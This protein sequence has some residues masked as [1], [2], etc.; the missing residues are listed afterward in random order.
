MAKYKIIKLNKADNDFVDKFL[1]DIREDDRRELFAM[2]ED[3]R[4]EIMESITFSA[5]C[6]AAVTEETAEPIVVFGR[7]MQPARD[8]A[9]IW[10]LGTDKLQEYWFP[11]L[12]ES[13]RILHGWAAEYDV[14]YNVVADFNTIHMRWLSWLGAKFHSSFDKNGATF[15]HFTIDKEDI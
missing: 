8:G 3:I 14:L 1:Q 12:R 13:R 2:T 6:Y 15:I 5:E 9:L 4:R 10:C 11:F 7:V